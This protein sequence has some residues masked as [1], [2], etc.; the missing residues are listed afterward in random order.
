MATGAVTIAPILGARI[1]SYIYIYGVTM[2]KY[3]FDG[4]T[5]GI[6]RDGI[7]A[8]LVRDGKANIDETNPALVALVEKHGG[9]AEPKAAQPAAKAK[10]SK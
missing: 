2:R 5:T 3:T 1:Y 9:K 4:L 10:R 8:I 6:L 7:N